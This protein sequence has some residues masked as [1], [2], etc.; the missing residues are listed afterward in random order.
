MKAWIVL[1][2]SVKNLEKL[3]RCDPRG[4]PKYKRMCI[5]NTSRL[6]G[7]RQ[8]GYQNVA[9]LS[10]GKKVPVRLKIPIGNLRISSSQYLFGPSTTRH[11]PLRC[12]FV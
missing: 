6:V 12:K 2:V 9:M 1:N 10:S 5:Y 3:L 8:P 4:A 11:S 7:Q